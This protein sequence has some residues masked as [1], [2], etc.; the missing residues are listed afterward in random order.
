MIDRE[1]LLENCNYPLAHPE[2]WAKRIA[3]T[4]KG[5]A[6]FPYIDAQGSPEVA[7]F[8]GSHRSP[9]LAVAA[10]NL[11]YSDEELAE[12]WRFGLEASLNGIGFAIPGWSRVGKEARSAAIEAGGAVEMHLG[13]GLL[14]CFAPGPFRVLCS[15]LI[16]AGGRIVSP[17]RPEVGNWGK[18]PEM[19]QYSSFLATRKRCI[20]VMGASKALLGAVEDALMAGSEVFVHRA[21]L[22]NWA[23]SA[24]ARDGAV[25][26]EGLAD[27][28]TKLGHEP[29]AWAYAA[30]GAGEWSRKGRGWRAHRLGAD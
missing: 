5:E 9:W 27:L 30:D 3:F 25:V 6:S 1:L 4:E 22:G 19:D 14:R 12:A 26:V 29:L 7:S 11:R 17:F 21:F 20:V 16:C 10:D 24:L 23:A 18:W 13:N 8:I 28:I 2:A 15:S